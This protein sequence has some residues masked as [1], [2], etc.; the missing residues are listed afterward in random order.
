MKEI[1]LLVICLI[2]AGH[3]FSQGKAGE[4]KGPVKVHHAKYALFYDNHTMPALPDVGANFDAE[5]FTD[6]IKRCGVDQLTFHARCNLGMA[7]YD[8]KIGIKH[9]SLKY[10][11]FGKLADACQQKDIALIAYLNGGISSQEGLLHRDWTTL[12]FD[13]REYREPRF[14]PFVRTMC[15]NSPYRD[16][17]IAMVEEIAGNY[18]VSGFFIDCLVG[19]PCVCPI[20]VKEMKEKGIDWNKL[21]QVTKFSEFSALRMS[22]DIAKAAKA[23]NPEFQLYF[24]GVSFE[25]QWDFG[26]WME[27][28]DLPTAG[29]GYEY[30]PV[31]SHFM[32]TLGDKPIMNMNGRFYDWGDFGGLRPEA[33]IKSELLY[34][35]ANGMRPNIGGHFHPRGDLENAVLD[36][37]EK[38]Y[39]ELQTMEPWFDN[40]K[41]ITEM[42]IV[43]PETSNKIGRSKQIKS[44][45]RM[46]SEMKQQF[47]VVT[48]FSDWS[49]YK[50]LVIPDDVIFN[51]EITRRIKAHVDEGKA[52]ISSG[53]SGLNQ[54]KKEFALEKEWGI[55]FIK[56][57]DFDPA[58]F[59]VGK[60]FSKGLPDMPLSLYSSGIEVGPLPGTSVEASLINPYFNRGWDGEFAFYY[61]PPDKVTDKPAL[62]IHGKVAHFSHRIFSG[63][64]DQA[65]VEL[66][67]VFG[68]VLDK[69]LPDPLVKYEKLPS[70]SRVFVTEQPGRKMVHLLS[71]VPE[72]RGS[73]T[74]IIEEPV[75]LHDVKIS[76]R[77]DGKTP[78]KV[79]LAPERK[80]LPFK[81]VDGYVNVTIPVNNGYS[82]VVFEE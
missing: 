45:T 70:F 71:Y 24:N 61:N 46:L 59:A 14:T 57:C 60:N 69:F 44:A 3:A 54:E 17:L 78:K 79:Y 52:V 18:P 27:C 37:I 29:W 62:T 7:Y 68:N 34:G 8:T 66:R 50:V 6:R 19:Y 58:Y 72:L 82:L 26:T 21:E 4:A 9:P 56:E 25:D 75:E 2:A 38:I 49:K 67:T 35:L 76:L 73:K 28:E 1:V 51:E 47:D 20:C 23:I 41:N 12:Y 55:K 53:S 77:N 16:H 11:L 33:A 65:S 63:Y 13:G 74:Q 43:S 81:I 36:R 15:Y 22:R 80:A 48:E 30:L 5:A 32:R 39:K 10:D 42:A 31:L 40:A 64:A